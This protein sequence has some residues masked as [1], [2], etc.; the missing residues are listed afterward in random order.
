MSG[1][2][3]FVG[4]RSDLETLDGELEAIRRTGEGRFVWMYGRRRVGKSRLVEEMAER[5]GLPY[6]FFQAP[7]RE[8]ANGLSRFRDELASSTLPAAEI[9]REGV[10][11]E[12]W[13]AALALAA[14]GARAERPVI[15]VIDEFPYLLEHDSG[16]AAD[17][18]QAWDRRLSREPVLLVCIGSDMRMMRALVEYPSELFGRPTREMRV[19]PF[20][21]REVGA[22]AGVGASEA[23]DRFLIVGGFPLLARSWPAELSWRPY[24]QRAF[25]DAAGPLVTDG[26]RILD[27]ELPGELRARD[28]LEAVGHGERTFTAIARNSG[29]SN[30]AALS[31]TLERLIRKGIVD[32]ALP[33]AAP[34]GRKSR[35]YAVVDPYLR[36][37]LRFLARGIEEIDRGRGDLL[38]ARVQR[39]WQTFAGK[40]IEPVVRRCVERLLPDERFGDAR[41]VGAY[42]TRSNNPE[43]DLVGAADPDPSAVSFIGSIKWRE[44]RPFGRA[45]TEQ[46]ILQRKQVPG[47]DGALLVGVSR[48][49]FAEDA[50]LDVALCPRDLIRAWPEP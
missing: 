43:V 39:D 11:L 41:Y 49:G 44:D 30:H 33:F 36:F 3:G 7:R 1:K 5:S 31:E 25:A 20:T 15:V 37:W 42:W 10:A 4:R 50:G 6:V 21:P 16:M 14:Q 8:I 34:P 45:D 24:L 19:E 32:A 17:L 28:V 38:L 13:P 27:A 18:Q 12:T 26:L 46:L 9:A 22:L 29:V 35:R 2:R 23:F 48:S 47:A 40:A